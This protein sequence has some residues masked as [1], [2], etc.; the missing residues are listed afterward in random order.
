ML[1]LLGTALAIVTSWPSTSPA[2]GPAA[3]PKSQ[4]AAAIRSGK[5]LLE[6]GEYEKAL[7]AFS[8][9]VRL[10]PDDGRAYYSRACVYKRQGQPDKAAA[11]LTRAVKLDPKDAWAYFDRGWAYGRSRQ[12]DKVIADMTE[13][14]RLSPED[15]WACEKRGTMFFLKGDYEQAVNDF[16]AAVRLNPA[17]PSFL[18]GLA[19]A[20]AEEGNLDKA[21]VNNGRA[22]RLNANPKPP[23]LGAYAAGAESYRNQARV[24][25]EKGRLDEAVHDAE[26]AV[27]LDP[28]DAENYYVCGCVYGKKG[29]PDKAA[30][31]L[32][33]A[34]RRDTHGGEPK[35]G[36]LISW[37]DDVKNF[38]LLRN[39]PVYGALGDWGLREDLGLS[40]A[41]ER[42]LREVTATFEAE[43]LKFED[44]LSKLPQK[45]QDAKRAEANEWEALQK[46]R[47]RL[48]KQIEGI[49]TPEQLDALKRRDRSAG[50]FYA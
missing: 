31:C 48:R 30:A 25:A 41:Q 5:A 37:A 32:A 29:E 34:V 20:Y 13:Q 6:D 42:R 9:A 27:R 11:D 26:Q 4:A 44:G 49:L 24:L 47:E 1:V 12:V 7:A 35:L 36:Y 43:R 50:L 15:C 2:Q 33:A 38:V 46:T 16:T 28:R 22:I 21:F 19:L 10:R 18:V 23:Y 8:D 45:E 17:N 40:P 3:D 39:L 14:I